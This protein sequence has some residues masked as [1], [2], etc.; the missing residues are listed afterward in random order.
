MNP[1]FISP[2]KISLFACDVRFFLVLR[3]QYS[4]RQRLCHGMRNTLI[5]L[6]FFTISD[7]SL[8]AVLTDQQRFVAAH[9]S[10]HNFFTANDVGLRRGLCKILLAKM[11]HMF[12]N[13][14]LSKPC[15]ISYALNSTTCC[16]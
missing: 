4:V 1:T 5:K 2:G 15:V 7:A 14:L 11:R 13:R 6:Q 12:S 9:R 8:F 3:R 10:L 16:S